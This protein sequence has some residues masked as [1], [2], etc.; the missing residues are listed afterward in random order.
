MPDNQSINELL[1]KIAESKKKYAF[2]VFI[3]SL[4]RDVPF[5][6]MTTLQQK[7]L[8][9]ASMTD[10]DRYSNTMYALFAIFQN[11][12]AEKSIEIGKFTVVDKLVLAL[13]MRAYSI[14]PTYKVIL[15]DMKDDNGKPLNASINLQNLINK[16]IKKFKGYKFSQTISAPGTDIK[17]EIGIPTIG[18]EVLIEREFEQSARKN[19]SNSETPD[20]SEGFGELYVLE[21]IKFL[22]SITIKSDTE[23]QTIDVSELPP[24]DKK[25]AFESLPAALAVEISKAVNEF[26]K[27]LNDITLLEVNHEGTKRSYKIELSDPDFF[28]G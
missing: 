2:P 12:C 25:K 27:E 4:G 22:K 3:P 15:N 28:I 14:S 7:E 10:T 9:K 20:Q 17:V 6:Q 5:Y 8:L 21:C 24:S 13:A 11:N 16:I 26:M 23:E 1:A 18:T 19:A